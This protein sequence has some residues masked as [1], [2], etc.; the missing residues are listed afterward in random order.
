[1]GGN[2]GLGDGGGIVAAV[3]GGFVRGFILEE[4]GRETWTELLDCR[5]VLPVVVEFVE[6]D[7]GCF[8]FDFDEIEVKFED[9]G[10]PFGYQANYISNRSE[11]MKGKGNIN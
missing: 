10:G 2:G 11:G 8:P 9:I 4:M 3:A 7:S 6:A 5:G 1:M